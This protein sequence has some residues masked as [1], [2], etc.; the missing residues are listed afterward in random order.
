MA[1]NKRKLSMPKP[2]DLELP[3]LN[4]VHSPER[5][6]AARKR[7]ET[8]RRVHP[9]ENRPNL[10]KPRQRPPE[11]SRSDQRS[12]INPDDFEIP[13]R[14]TRPRKSQP[15]PK[16]ITIPRQNRRK[17]TK[18][19]KATLGQGARARIR[20]HRKFSFNIRISPAVKRIFSITTVGVAVMAL[21][22]MLVI[23]LG[24]HNA[25]AVFLDDQ[26]MG[27]IS[28]H[29]ELDSETVHNQAV[30][31]LESGLGTTAIV[32]QRVTITAARAR[33]TEIMSQVDMRRLLTT[34]FTY[35]IVATAIYVEGRFEALVRT[36]SCAEH[37]AEMLK[38]RWVTD[39]TSYSSFVEEW[40]L[41]PR[42]IDL[43]F[44]EADL[45]S[46]QEALARLDRMTD[47]RTTH[48]VQS[49]DMLSTLAVQY[50]TT[51]DRIATVN[52]MTRHAML[53]IG[54]ELQIETRKP[55]LS[56]RTVDET[57]ITEVIPMPIEIIHNADLPE[58][59]RIVI[60]EGQDGEQ[61]IARR[62]IR[63]DGVQVDYEVLQYQV[64]RQPLVHIVEE[65]TGV[66]IIERR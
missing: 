27:Y 43:E 48:I 51:I 21:V 61:Q 35:Q 25:L 36:E 42:V 58:S 9:E 28:M 15:Q 5:R 45:F 50:N 33:N 10:R 20:P 23:N 6:E 18:F 31:H 60:Q 40:E 57:I 46:P 8:M 29:P 66:A 39:T 11:P 38:D 37:V 64:L 22:V 44:D 2:F 30:A 41:H 32:D 65:G 1:E 63:I 12:Y 16:P 62:I 53:I 17:K 47:A 55:L 52:N 49:G 13:R 56:V 4:A 3:R 24:R 19:K 26:H 59:Q 54:M 7:E 14:N 34:E